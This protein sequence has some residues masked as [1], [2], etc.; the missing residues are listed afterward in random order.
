MIMTSKKKKELVPYEEG[1]KT[2]RNKIIP[3]V[4]P[5]LQKEKVDL[6]KAIEWID[7]Y[8]EALLDDKWNW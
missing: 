7:G 2:A 8:S 3:S 4:C 1:A 6:T 5:Y